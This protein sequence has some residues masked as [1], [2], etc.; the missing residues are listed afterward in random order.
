VTKPPV[1]RLAPRVSEAL[2]DDSDDEDDD[3]EDDDD[4]EGAAQ[5]AEAVAKVSV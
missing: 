1:T 3:D 2:E 4:E 5:V